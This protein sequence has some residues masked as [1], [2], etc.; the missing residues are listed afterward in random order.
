LQKVH[1][2]NPKILAPLIVL[3]F[4][5]HCSAAPLDDLV[6]GAKKEGQIELYAPSTLTPQGAQALGDAFNKK[7]GLNTRVQYS[8]AGQMERDVTKLMTTAAAGIAPEWDIMLVT[9]G[10]AYP[11]Q[12]KKAW[13]ELIGLPAG[14]VRPLP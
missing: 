3:T 14:P 4:F 5:V 7:Y 6:A 12:M 9:D 2:L 13:A 11:T 1:A 8:P 10:G